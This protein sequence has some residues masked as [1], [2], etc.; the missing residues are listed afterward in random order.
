MAS[1]IWP[2][3]I[4]FGKRYVVVDNIEVEKRL[5]SIVSQCRVAKDEHVIELANR[6]AQRGQDPLAK[7]LQS[8]LRHGI[9]PR[10]F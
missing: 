3:K 10:I 7:A 9:I 2:R 6:H 4:L 5:K 1:L 8:A